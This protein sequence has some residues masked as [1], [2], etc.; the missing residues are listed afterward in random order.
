MGTG[1]QTYG[2]ATSPMGDLM[3]IT[4][5]IEGHHL[6]DL[7]AGTTFIGM[8]SSVKAPD[9]TTGKSANCHDPLIRVARLCTRK[10]DLNTIPDP[11]EAAI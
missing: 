2:V 9:P 11:P 3:A 6:K 1:H 8:R 10:A 5:Q 4:S 7:H